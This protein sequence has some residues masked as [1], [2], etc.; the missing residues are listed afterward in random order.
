MPAMALLVPTATLPQGQGT[1]RVAS[2]VTNAESSRDADGSGTRRG[3]GP[4]GIGPDAFLKLLVAQ[5]RYQD[6]L[7]PMQD[8]AFMTQLVQLTQLEEMRGVHRV[9]TDFVGLALLG[10]EV[11]ITTVDGDEMRGPVTGVYLD[12]E[13]PALAIG[14][15]RVPWKDITALR[16]PDAPA[17]SQAL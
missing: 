12:P 13:E 10:R 17:T 15:T 2:T 1:F 16:L 3:V 5:L 7:R 8:S 11:E 9:L 6:P 14:G 4:G